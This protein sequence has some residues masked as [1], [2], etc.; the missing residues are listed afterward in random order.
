MLRVFV[1]FFGIITLMGCAA[2]N[3]SKLASVSRD[4]VVC[5]RVK[6]T[7]SNIP[8]R[9]CYTKEQYE[10]KKK[11]DAKDA[12]RTMQDIQQRPRFRKGN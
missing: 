3:D 6:P 2:K 1:M 5:E 4:D 7:G 11:A 10:D 12:Q 8:K 9:Q